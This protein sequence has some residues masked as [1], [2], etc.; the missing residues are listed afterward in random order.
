MSCELTILLPCLNEAETI[1]SCVLEASDFLSSR[2][3][4][5]EV[6]VADN[7]SSDDSADLA[8]AVGARVVVVPL[9]GYGAALIGGMEVA[10][11]RYII[12]GD[13]DQSYDLSALDPFVEALRSG[14]DLVIG[15][16]FRGGIEP[17]AMPPLHRY[18][19]NP[20]LSFIG[21]LFFG[22]P[23][24]DFHC[25]LRGIN[26][27][28]ARQ[29]QL[30]SLGMEC[31]SEM[32]VRAVLAG[33]VVVEVPT[34][35]RPDGRSRAPHLR[36][37]RDGWRHLR[38]LLLY[39]PRWLLLYPGAGLFLI[40]L[41]AGARL[42]V[43]AVE[44]G[45]VTFDV[46]SLLV[47]AGVALIGYE[48][49][50]F[51]VLSKAFASREGLLPADVHVASLVQKFPLERALLLSLLGVVAGAAGLIVAFVWW[52]N[53]N[54]GP[55]ESPRVMR[56][57]ILSVFT[58]VGAMLTAFSSVFLSLLG[59]RSGRETAYQVPARTFRAPHEDG[60]AS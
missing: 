28:T 60:P 51:A 7:G 12:M 20:L 21:R 50:W 22:A 34:T 43:G 52:R 48:S 24:G 13:A 54:F 17:G 9:R 45:S 40:G 33:H 41:V 29:L 42:V 47:C 44:I 25:G 26:A 55:I 31:A 19:G 53:L 38:F 23:V 37:F 14:A 2:G 58:V 10:R 49:M 27:E 36:T 56:L 18:V 3:I 30:Q 5:G 15:N 57:A 35:L 6:L 4:D 8:R 11:G 1:Q 16:R 59:L 39:S 32:V 46:I